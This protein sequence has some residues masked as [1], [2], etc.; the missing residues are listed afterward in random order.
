MCEKRS[1]SRKRSTWT[2]PGRQTRER[3]LRPRSTS[4]MC[5]ARSFSEA[6]SRAASPSPGLVEPAIGLSA[7]ARALALDERLGRGA[8][9][10][11]AV[12]LEQEEVG[13]G[14]DAAQRAVERERRDADVG[15]SA[16]CE[17]T[18]WKASPRADRLLAGDDARARSPPATGSGGSGRCGARL[19]RRRRR[20]G[21]EQRDR[22]GGRRAST[23]ATPR[24]WSKRTSVSAT[25]KR[26]SGR[27]GPASGSGTVGSSSDDEVVA[28]VADDRLAAAPRPRR[29]R[30]AAS[31]SRRASSARAGPARPT[32]AGRLRRACA[33]QAQ[34]GPER[35]QE[36]GGEAAGRSAVIG[37][38]ACVKKTLAGLG[39]AG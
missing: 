25:T 28:E 33:A 9:E 35:G 21:R 8:D 12:E 18:I 32:R 6:S 15:R 5:S 24:A 16:R 20:L 37:R 39:R 7:G 34:V 19:A 1:G 36:V 17:S 2:L 38:A 22:L 29:R 30:A 31:R 23:S 10:R 11:D 26:L 4:M 3:S 14:V 27:P 13:G